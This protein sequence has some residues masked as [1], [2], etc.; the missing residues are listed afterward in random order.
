MSSNPASPLSH[1]T[2]D[3]IA[4]EV[5]YVAASRAWWERLYR[6]ARAAWRC[7]RAARAAKAAP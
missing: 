5:A 3:T 1:V 2:T 7:S 4:R 6:S